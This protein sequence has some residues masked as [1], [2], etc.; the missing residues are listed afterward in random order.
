M[1]RVGL[2]NVHTSINICIFQI[3]ILD[4]FIQYLKNAKSFR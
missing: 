1:Q 4:F 3:G 2:I